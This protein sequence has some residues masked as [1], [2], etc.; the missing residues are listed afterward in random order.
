MIRRLKRHIARDP[1]WHAVGLTFGLLFSIMLMVARLYPQYFDHIDQA[2]EIALVPYQTFGHVELFLAVTVLGSATGVTLIAACAAV[3]LRKNPFAIL[4]L[5][6][7]LLFSSVSMGIAKMFVERTRPDALLWL[8][9]LNTYSFPSG[10]ATLATA[11]FGF[12]A[13]YLYRYLRS[14]FARGLALASCTVVVAFVCA[15]RLV[16][17]F[18]YFTDV[19]GGVLLGLF[20]LAV[21]FMMPKPR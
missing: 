12:I 3:L 4:Q 19:L 20:W 7:L 17:N 11:C 13:V 10:H 9:P 5:F 14:E 16:L 15:S 2:V 1:W 8:D 21:V 18:H 6:L